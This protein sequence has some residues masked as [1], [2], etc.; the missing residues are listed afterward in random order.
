[1]HENFHVE[2]MKQGCGIW[3]LRARLI[4]ACAGFPSPKLLEGMRFEH[5]SNENFTSQNYQLTTNP[6]EEWRTVKECDQSKVSTGSGGRMI[7]SYKALF[8]KEK[9]RQ[10]RDAESKEDGAEGRSSAALTEAEII[11]IILY[12]GPMVCQQRVSPAQAVRIFFAHFILSNS[13][14]GR[15]KF[16]L[17]PPV[18]GSEHT[19]ICSDEET[20]GFNLE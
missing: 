17:H 1:M 4:A 15:P 7:P 8:E 6:A 12:T 19:H 18:F 9:E 3:A 10:E 5:R 11:A 13:I 14:F 2:F 20:T 16:G